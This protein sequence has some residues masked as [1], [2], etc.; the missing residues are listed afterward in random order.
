MRKILLASAALVGAAGLANAQPTA[1]PMAPTQG[2]TAM[3]TSGNPPA[4]VN[5]SNNMAAAATKGAVANPTPGS[6]VIHF[7]GRVSSGIFASWGSG[8]KATGAKINP[9]A[10]STYARLYTG[11]D[12]MTTGGMRYG[13]AIEVRENFV[14]ASS[15]TAGTGASGYSSG[16]TLFVRRAFGYVASEQLGILRVGQAD[17]LISLYDNGITTFQFLPTGNL[18]G[19]DTEVAPAG[20][21]NVP[22]AN[23]AVAGNEYDNSKLVY[24]SPSFSGFDFGLQWAPN[25]SNG[26]APCTVAATGCAN[27]SSSATAIDGSR[28]LNQTAVGARYKGNLGGVDVLAY[29][30]YMFSGHANYTGAAIAAK[31]AA[32][33][34]STGGTGKF[35]NLSFGNIGLA[36]TYAGLT[37]GG[38]VNFGNVNNQGALKPTGGASQVAVVAGVKYATGPLTVGVVGEIID[39]QGAPQLVGLTQRHEVGI[40]GGA[41]YTL[42]PGL[43]V[44]AEYVYQ[45]RHQGGFN[46]ATSTAGSSA[47]NDVKS[48]AL[49]MGA[50]VYW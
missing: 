18:N 31:S 46:F 20:I 38:N 37:V 50:T 9:V 13:G 28:I 15:S 14:A 22:F 10:L 5:N 44:W 26:Y 34:A 21:A 12:G 48:H 47:F 2:Q 33:L 27:L 45:Q 3:N 29:G 41:S 16:Q 8:D 32:A 25:T 24:L 40:S 7:N 1:M 11:V 42:A 36:G 4:G 49:G 43:V 39:H 30:V 17:G 6:V 35:E 19:G 23:F